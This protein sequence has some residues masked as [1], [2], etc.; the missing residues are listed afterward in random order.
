[1]DINVYLLKEWIT[2][3]F[4]V[5]PTLC[6]LYSPLVEEFNFLI[7]VNS[8]FWI[9][10]QKWISTAILGFVAPNICGGK[11]NISYWS[12]SF[13]FFQMFK[14]TT[15]QIWKSRYIFVQLQKQHPENFAFLILR[16]IEFFA[17]KVCKFLKN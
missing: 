15:M 13:Y 11:I 3:K 16:I 14:V 4:F 2:W 10:L 5:V 17:H 12:F 8:A 6:E 1:M 9:S 7:N